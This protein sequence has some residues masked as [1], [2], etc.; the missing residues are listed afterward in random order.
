MPLCPYAPMPLCAAQRTLIAGELVW[1]IKRHMMKDQA[2]ATTN[3]RQG[4][5]LRYFL[6]LRASAQYPLLVAVGLPPGPLGFEG[7]VYP[8]Q[9]AR[10]SAITMSNS[11]SAHSCCTGIRRRLMGRI[12]SLSLL[13]GVSVSIPIPLYG[14]HIYGLHTQVTEKGLKA[15]CFQ[16]GDEWPVSLA[17]FSPIGHNCTV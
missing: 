11:N 12:L 6:L 9:A 2:P 8:P 1:V 7:D 10:L 15:P 3:T 16:A 13:E 17:G 14:L 5:F 4:A